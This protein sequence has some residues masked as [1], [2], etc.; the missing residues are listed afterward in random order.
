M[1]RIPALVVG[2]CVLLLVSAAW[3]QEG[4]KPGKAVRI[5]AVC[6]SWEAKDRNLPHVLKMLEQ[7]A[8]ERAQIV[9]LPEECVPTDG[10]PAA[11]AALDAIAKTAAARSM[12]VVA[13]L[14]EKDGDKTYSTSYLIGADGKILGKYR[15]SHR[16][17]YEQVALG[18][19]LPVFDTPHGKIAIPR[20]GSTPRSTSRPSGDSSA[21]TPIRRPSTAA[22]T[23]SS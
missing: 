22:P 15:K 3:A 19:A 6:Q 2:I 12:M 16:L 13:N 1:T 18:N 23:W 11:Q 9:C 17:P 4:V 7:A 5:C 21:S 14:K 20:P 10:G 8:E